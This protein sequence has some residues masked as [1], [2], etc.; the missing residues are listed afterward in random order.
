[1]QTRI[2]VELRNPERH[3]YQCELISSTFKAIVVKAGRRS[4]KT[5]GLSIR[6]IKK[7]LAG[8]RV[9]YVAPTTAQTDKYWFEV[10]RALMPAVL[11][12]AYKKSEV[13]RYIELP[14]TEN[15]IT[16]K[17]AWNADILRG[18]YADELQLDEIQLMDEGV[19]DEVGRPMLLD[20][21]GDVVFCFTPPSLAS[22]EKSRA[23]DP[24]WASKLYDKAKADTTGRWGTLHFTSFDNPFISQDTIALASADMS[25]DSYR[26]EILAEDD[27]ILNSWLVYGAFNSQ[28]QIIDGMPEGWQKW[29]I[30][31][32]HDFGMANPAALFVACHPGT[33]AFYVFDEY[34]PNSAHSTAEN[35]TEFQSKTQGLNITRRVGGNVT[36]EEEI[37]QGYTVQGW[38]IKA[39]T[40]TKPSAQIDR[41]RALVEKDKIFILRRCIKVLS[42][43]SNCLWEIDRENRPTDKIRNESQFHLLACWRYLFSEFMPQ[44][45]NIASNSKVFQQFF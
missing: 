45:V 26:R 35:I 3:Q 29:L 23:R 30:Y 22:S 32:G 20:R 33:G 18:D 9:L 16:A 42:E 17:T 11:A 24:R 37:R 27:D 13:E 36:T 41:V 1:M 34:C 2:K 10:N 31:V 39:P 44:N 19:W 21:N 15:R 8:K 25:L 12:G 14:G 5:T 4:A 7:F 6:G 40:I 43:L 28:T 38:T